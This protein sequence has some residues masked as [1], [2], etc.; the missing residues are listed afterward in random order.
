MLLLRMSTVLLMRYEWSKFKRSPRHATR[1]ILWK[2]SLIYFF[3]SIH[4]GNGNH[5]SWPTP[6]RLYGPNHDPLSF[7]ERSITC[8]CACMYLTGWLSHMFF[9]FSTNCLSRAIGFEK[10]M[11]FEFWTW[12]LIWETNVHVDDRLT[13]NNCQ[14]VFHVKRVTWVVERAFSP[15]K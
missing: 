11:G 6:I 4:E 3:I 12:N 15:P 5:D 13:I 8:A 9:T 10:F 2:K 14:V 1:Y 7:K